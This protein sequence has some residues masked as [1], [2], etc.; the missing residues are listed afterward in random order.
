MKIQ[1]FNINL[2]RF[3]LIRNQK[4]TFYS[5]I[6]K[7]VVD[8]QYRS[9]VSKFR[10]KS[11]TLMNKIKYKVKESWTKIFYS[12]MYT[13]VVYAQNRRSNVCK[14]RHLE[15]K[16]QHLWTKLDTR[17]QILNIDFFSLMYKKVADAQ[18]RSKL[19][20][21]LMMYHMKVGRRCLIFHLF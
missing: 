12:L 5:L 19:S 10:N 3:L 17:L 15:T 16:A 1:N 8:A 20:N 9:N 7:K 14:I 13:V 21:E 6:Y 2:S 11:S 4:L 18:Y